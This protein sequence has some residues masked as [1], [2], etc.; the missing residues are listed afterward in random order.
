MRCVFPLAGRAAAC[1]AERAVLFRPGRHG[2]QALWPSQALW[3]TACFLRRNHRAPRSRREPVRRHSL[4]RSFPL[5]HPLGSA[6]AR[7]DLHDGNLQP[8]IRLDP[9]HPPPRHCVGRGAGGDPGD[10][11]PADRVADVLL[12]VPGLAGGSLRPAPADRDRRPAHRAVL[13]TVGLRQFADHVVPDLWRAGRTGH[14]HR[15]C[16]RRRP[17]GGLVPGQARPCHRRG[18]G[19]LWLRCHPHHLPDREFDR[20]RRLPGDTAAVWRDL[21]R[22]RI[23]GRP[24]PEG[25][26]RLRALRVEARGDRAGQRHR[27]HAE[28]ADLLADVL[29]DDA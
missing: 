28:V 15:L 25:A 17:N 10:V 24:R 12:A 9:V 27:R 18:G 3:P 8:A 13:D 21:R 1:A 16:R 20:Q 6:R 26:A 23:P 2:C 5:R 22:R 7:A 4:H 11:L 14:R 19:G 29:H